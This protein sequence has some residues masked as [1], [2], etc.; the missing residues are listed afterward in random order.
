M[1]TKLFSYLLSFCLFTWYILQFG[2][3]SFVSFKLCFNLVMPYT[4]VGHKMK[5]YGYVTQCMCDCEV[6]GCIPFLDCISQC[7]KEHCEFQGIPKVWYKI[8]VL[9]LVRSLVQ[10]KF[11]LPSSPSFP[12]LEQVSKA[13]EDGHWIISLR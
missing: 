6:A 5:T 8:S 2:N 11:M 9:L 10:R 4:A 12:K 3:C 7:H 13:S 1:Q